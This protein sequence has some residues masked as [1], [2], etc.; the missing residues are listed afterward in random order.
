MTASRCPRALRSARRKR[1]ARAVE[2]GPTRGRLRPT[3]PPALPIASVTSTC[4]R[5]WC[6]SDGGVSKE[7][8]A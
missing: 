4:T 5:A 6:E 1:H 8:E 3:A 7:E 2:R